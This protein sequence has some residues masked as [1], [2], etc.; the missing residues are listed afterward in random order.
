[1][2]RDPRALAGGP[3]DLLVV[4]AGVYGSCAAWDAAQ[5]GLSVALVD[6]GDVG[7]ET[8]A[9]SQKLVHGGLR[10][11][12]K[13]Q[14]WRMRESI[15][16]RRAFLRIAP[17]LVRPLA[18][19]LPAYGHGLRGREA[20]RAALALNDLLSRDRNRADG[21]LPLAPTHHVPPG[22]VLTR[23]ECLR[24]FPDLPREGLTGA[25]VWS[26]GLM[27]SSERVTLA[28]ALAAAGAGAAVVT[29]ARVLRLLLETGSGGPRVAGALVRDELEGGEVEVR[30][31]AV[32]NAAGPWGGELARAAGGAYPPGEFACARGF[33]VVVDRDLVG[34]VAL[35]IPGRAGDA[36]R[37][38]GGPLSWRR[39][40]G[41]RRVFFLT[42]WRGRTV[43]G[44][45]YLPHAGPLDAV[46][47]SA[48]EVAEFLSAVNA[49]Y[50]AARLL[51]EEVTFVQRGLLPL[52]AG[53]AGLEIADD[54]RLYDAPLWGG[55]AGLVTLRG[56]KYTTARA[57]AEE[58]VDLVCARLRVAARGR[59]ASTLLPHATPLPVP[60]GE[61]AAGELPPHGTAPSARQV[62]HAVRHE[63]AARLSDV[64]LRRTDA[65]AA[66]PP[67]P[68]VLEDVAAV[69]ARELGWDE[70][71]RRCEIEELRRVYE[72]LADA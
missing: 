43:V 14:L 59:T 57:A 6:R 5:R 21:A 49:A 29:Y 16:E 54:H 11:L 70:T 48:R 58:A 61:A 55:P 31:R 46:R 51:P 17:A 53:A 47:V 33:S 12:Q 8:S 65:G 25:G 22:R 19:V 63:G 67:A 62:L 36:V 60:E 72:P 7:G 38:G 68:G 2:R 34:D 9:N 35:G 26:D 52:R 18:C 45:R 1:M 64:V 40:A 56:V 10:Y 41:E 28:F 44:T 13:A 15:R 3:F 24:L 71:R 39:V 50:P 69:M 27:R 42:P 30:A 37:S 20:L 32:L 4:G 23:E 66:G